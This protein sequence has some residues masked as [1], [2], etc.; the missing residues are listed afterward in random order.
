MFLLCCMVITSGGLTEDNFLL[1]YDK[2]SRTLRQLNLEDNSA[3]RITIEHQESRSPAYDP[4]Q[5]RV[6]WIRY[7]YIK[8]G[9]LNE[10][11]EEGIILRRS[12]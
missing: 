8:R 1:L 2:S 11:H 5:K 3:T 4:V 12:S 7:P 6:Y 10:T 9:Y